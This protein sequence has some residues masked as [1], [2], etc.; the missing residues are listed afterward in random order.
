MTA[1]CPVPSTGPGPR[2]HQQLLKDYVSIPK[3]HLALKSVIPTLLIWGL[4]MGKD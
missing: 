3:E 4:E 1:L 2:D